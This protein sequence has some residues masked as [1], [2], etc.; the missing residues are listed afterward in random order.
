MEMIN[1]NLVLHAKLYTQRGTTR[2]KSLGHNRVIP[3]VVKPAVLF[4]LIDLF[5]TICR[6]FVQLH[7]AIVYTFL[8]KQKV[9]EDSPS[10]YTYT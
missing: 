10:T 6:C 9:N 7:I 8:A 3:L 1:P 5:L 2:A 4:V